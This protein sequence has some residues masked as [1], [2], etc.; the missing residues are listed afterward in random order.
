MDASAP[1]NHNGGAKPHSPAQ[2]KAPAA[3]LPQHPVAPSAPSAIDLAETIKTLLH[4]AHEN[5]HV[6]YDDINDVLPEGMSPEELDELARRL[7]TAGERIDRDDSL[8][9]VRRF[10]ATDPWGNRLELL[11]AN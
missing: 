7:E 11:A 2:P 8:P 4:L 1:E 9:G 5:G 3:S 10:Y 6:T